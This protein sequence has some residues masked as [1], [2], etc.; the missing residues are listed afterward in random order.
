MHD[1]A[2]RIHKPLYFI[3]VSVLSG[4]VYY[5]V[6]AAASGFSHP[7]LNL[8]LFPFFMAL[9]FIIAGA[10][11]ALSFRGIPDGDKD[12]HQAGVRK[13]AVI[14]IAALILSAIFP[15][16][17]L[18]RVYPVPMAMFHLLI[19]FYAGLALAAICTAWLVFFWR[20]QERPPLLHESVLVAAAILSLVLSYAAMYIY[21]LLLNR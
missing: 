8:F 14:V 9:L 7:F 15:A 11:Y 19:L 21:G 16:A 1:A 4:G 20:E 2:P 3:M 6:L 12:A 18:V 10:V 5:L 17:A 13:T